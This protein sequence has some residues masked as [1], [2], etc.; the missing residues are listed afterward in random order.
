MLPISTSPLNRLVFLR[1]AASLFRRLR[2]KGKKLRRR[3]LPSTFS[4]W[5][6]T[7]AYD[8]LELGQWIDAECILARQFDERSGNRFRTDQLESD[9]ASEMAL[10]AARAAK[11]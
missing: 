3:S 9:E 8:P 10:E 4:L 11:S 5:K 6:K 2:K 7:G 1:H